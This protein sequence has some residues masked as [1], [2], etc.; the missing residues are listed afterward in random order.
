MCFLCSVEFSHAK[1]L[2]PLNLGR[3]QK[4]IDDGRIDPSH[5]ITMKDLVD[6][7][8]VNGVKYGVKLLADVR[9]R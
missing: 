4:W 2:D 9:D 3:L 5:V 8:I 1:P 6:S 7:R